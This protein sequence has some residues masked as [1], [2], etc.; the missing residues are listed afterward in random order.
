MA[1]PKKN[2]HAGHRERMREKYRRVGGDALPDHELLEM[3]LFFA[4]PRNNT[5]DIAHALLD[6]FGSIE[7]IISASPEALEMI[8]GIGEHSSLL[9]ALIGD[10]LRHIARDSVKSKKKHNKKYNNMEDIVDYLHRLFVGMSQECVYL[11]TFDNGMRLIDTVELARGEVNHV[12]IDPHRLMKEA[13]RHNASAVLIAH[14]HPDGEAQPS[15]A[16]QIFTNKVQYLLS[17]THITLI[18]H[19]I[20]SGKTYAS[21]LHM[22]GDELV[23]VTDDFYEEYSER[24][25]RQ[26]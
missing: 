1:N 26:E 19:L 10:V 9:L 8:D 12:L 16:D 22:Y 15:E 13:M 11:M 14:N 5:N 17:T 3:L 2:L 4:I 24:L 25:S 23:D 6:R 7:G 18:D 20:F 21:I